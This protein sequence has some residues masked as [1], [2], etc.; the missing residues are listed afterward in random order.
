[1]LR[2]CQRNQYGMTETIKDYEAIVMGTSAGGLAALTAI[3]ETLPASYRLPILIVQHRARDSRDLFEDVLQYKCRIAIK[4]ADEKEKITP[5]HV[6]VAPPDY[7]MLVEMDKTISLSS[8][9]PVQ[10]SRPSIDVLF[11]SAAI[12]YRS[13]LIGIILTGSNNDGA[14][15]IRTIAAMGGLTIA[16][17]PHEAQFSYMTQAA[18][19]TKR[20]SH[21]W[22]LANISRFL[23]QF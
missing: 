19:D 9:A 2:Q 18:I 22:T 13:K 14:E 20:V 4:Q 17:H 23:N 10:F 1:M 7:H 12:V 8:E 16:Q 3:L 5:G 11:E 6:Y 15:G 21:V